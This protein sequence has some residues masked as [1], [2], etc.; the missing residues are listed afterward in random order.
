MSNVLQ[1]LA[2]QNIDHIC[3]KLEVPLFSY[4]WVS[5]ILF[6]NSFHKQPKISNN[7]CYLISNSDFL[8]SF[9][10]YFVIELF[11]QDH[12]LRCST[13]QLGQSWVITVQLLFQIGPQYEKYDLPYHWSTN[14]SQTNARRGPTI[15]G[16]KSCSD[17][18]KI[19]GSSVFLLLAEQP[20]HFERVSTNSKR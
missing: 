13:K 17:T 20:Y 8:H 9:I 15:S 14:H 6:H 19:R 18:L 11:H 7:L 16:S 2:G 5:T 3:Y 4:C 10:F 1:L 12:L